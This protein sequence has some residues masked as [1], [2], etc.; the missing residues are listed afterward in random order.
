M[1]ES[2]VKTS[3]SEKFNKYAEIQSLNLSLILYCDIN[4]DVRGANQIGYQLILLLT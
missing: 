4:I 1:K 3:I 2:K